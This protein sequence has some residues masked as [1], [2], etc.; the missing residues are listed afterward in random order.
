MRVN[1]SNSDLRHGVSMLALS[2]VAGIVPTIK[3]RAVAKDGKLGSRMDA[4]ALALKLPKHA[5]RKVHPLEISM[6]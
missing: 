6:P 5:W 2:Y 4:K 1:G 3:V